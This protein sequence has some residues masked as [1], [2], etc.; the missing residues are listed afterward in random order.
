MADGGGLTAFSLAPRKLT[1]SLFFANTDAPHG[2]IL[3]ARRS[4]V[5]R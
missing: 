1:A 4:A 5:G 3:V 2:D